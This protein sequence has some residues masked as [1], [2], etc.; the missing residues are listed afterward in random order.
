VPQTRFRCPS[1]STEPARII[2]RALQ[3]YGAYVI[4][5]SAWSFVGLCVEWGPN[6]RVL[7]EVKKTWGF[8]L[9]TELDAKTAWAEDI[10]SGE[11]AP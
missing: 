5:D 10:D 9:P 3:D 2:A 4:D 6:G 7:T 8:D 1:L 11:E